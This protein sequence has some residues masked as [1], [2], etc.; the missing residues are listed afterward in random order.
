MNALEGH[1]QDFL[2]NALSLEYNLKRILKK[3]DIKNLYKEKNPPLTELELDFLYKRYNDKKYDMYLDRNLYDLLDQPDHDQPDHDQSDQD[4]PKK[5]QSY[6]HDTMNA[7]RE[8]YSTGIVN[9]SMLYIDRIRIINKY[10]KSICH[11]CEKRTTFLCSICKIVRYCSKECQR[12]DWKKH[13]E[14]CKSAKI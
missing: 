12:I 6:N 2:K 9:E 14:K 5:K 4:Q 3:K 1:F 7:V 13:K 8:A 11:I 10:M